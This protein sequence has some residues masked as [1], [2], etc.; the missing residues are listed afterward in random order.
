M[1]YTFNLETER[2]QFVTD[3]PV[4]VKGPPGPEIRKSLPFDA[5]P[6]HNTCSDISSSR[7]LEAQGDSAALG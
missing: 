5:I 4:T 3:A 7:K 6:E 2:V 1:K